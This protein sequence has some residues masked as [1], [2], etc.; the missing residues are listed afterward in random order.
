MT[1]SS[2]PSFRWKL[3]FLGPDGLRAGWAVAL[4]FVILI[5]A[6]ITLKSIAFLLHYPVQTHA[7]FTPARVMYAEA[8]LFSGALLATIGMARIDGRTWTGYGLCSRHGLTQ[9]GQ[10]AVC[11]L[12]VVAVV[13]GALWLSHAVSI[14]F[15]GTGARSLIRSGVLWTL[16]FCWV[17]TTE[18]IVFRGFVFFR[19]SRALNPFA[20]A[21]VASLLFAWVHMP[22]D[23]ETMIGLSSA[24]GFGLVACLTVWRTGSVWWA[25]GLHAAW[26][27]SETFLFGT[28]DS[29]FAATG[30]L[31]ISQPIGPTWLSGGTAGP[32]GSVVIFPALVLLALIVMW[33][34]PHRQGPSVAAT[35]F[36]AP[37][38]AES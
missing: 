27:W 2:T 24:L 18:E 34:L 11:G 20:A 25:L 33:I 23:G 13:M 8:V 9:F 16:A 12:L 21:I 10:G 29:G 30:N 31:L 17:A 38:A 14:T 5:A 4:F 26:D 28:T 7:P 32:E 1:R 35:S 37:P 36:L 22:N 15:S 6:V 3:L 19:L